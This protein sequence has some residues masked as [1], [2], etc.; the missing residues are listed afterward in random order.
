MTLPFFD[1]RPENDRLR[2]RIEA[3]VRRVLDAPRLILGPEVEA[4]EREFAAWLGARHGVG[5]NS[6]TDALAL[7]LRA[8]GVGR[9]DE[10]LTVA[11]AGAPPVAA[12]RALGARPRFVDVDPATLVL[13]PDRL[14][15]AIGPRTR[16]VLPVH[17]YGQPAP[18]DAIRELAD[19]RG[20]PVVED[21]A[22]SHG[23]TLGGR[24]TGTLGRIAAFSFYPT[25]N[26]G[27]VGDGGLCATD[28]DDLAARLRRLRFYG[29]DDERR[30]LEDGANTR[31]D[32]LQA[33]ILRVK[34]T[35]LDAAV[36]ERQ[37]L[38]AAYDEALADRD[39]IPVAPGAG[40][41]HARHLYVVRCR[42]R[43]AVTAALDD[44]G[45]G[46][47]VHYPV[48]AHRMPAYAPFA[49]EPLPV[50]E[51]ACDEVLSLPL[52][53]GLPGDAVERVATALP[54]RG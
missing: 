18:L 27:A 32:E 39:V 52:H 49:D 22:Q 47:A 13:D 50:T 35:A 37:A 53:P 19:A 10:V 6:G 7:A 4:F 8:V 34:L 29:F 38:A 25:K 42:D 20:L 48:P 46:W 5:V 31:L 12:V 24:P 40:C 28:D 15:D 11:N 30:A 43:A 9:D 44:A 23:A 45:V 54:A 41:E 36:A 51:R 26:L 1:P 3:A 2:A 14:A 16:A 21:C 17:L 33:A